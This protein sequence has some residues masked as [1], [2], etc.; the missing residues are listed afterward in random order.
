M[1]S[2]NSSTRTEAGETEV[3]VPPAVPS[4]PSASTWGPEEEGSGSGGVGGVGGSNPENQG[5]SGSGGGA[6]ADVNAVRS[7]LNGSCHL[8]NSA[9]GSFSAHQSK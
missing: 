6:S 3:S 9:C 2:S 5:L 8:V 7:H 1:P 4:G